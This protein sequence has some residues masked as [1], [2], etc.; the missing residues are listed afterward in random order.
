MD[1]EVG[2]LLRR[3]LELYEDTDGALDVTIYPAVEVWGFPDRAYRVP[4]EE[5]LTQIRERVNGGLVELTPRESPETVLLPWSMKLDL[6]AL[7]KGYAADRIVEIWREMGVTSGL[8]NL[9]GN[10][11]CLGAK[12]DGSDWTIGVRD[13]EDEAGTLCAVTGQDM[14]V[15]TSGAYQRNFSQNGVTYHH[16]LD[17]Q[18]CAPA[19]SGASSVTVIGPSGFLCDGLST[20][21]YVMGP[22]KAVE[23]W[24][25]H[26]NFDMIY[27]TQ[28]GRLLYTSGLEGRLSLRDGLEGQMLTWQTA[29]L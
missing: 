20:A 16:I 11:H 23:Y 4:S 3:A 19:D 8:L 13:P 9:G 2:E 10:V 29:G 7:G 14:A 25:Q 1:R 21:L 28:D 18:T 15:V 26:R 24:Q 5:D 6:G 12:P 27:Y 17:P 22:D